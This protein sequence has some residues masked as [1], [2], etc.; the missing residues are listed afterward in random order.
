MHFHMHL[1][2]LVY[3]HHSS[4]GRDQLTYWSCFFPPAYFTQY[5]NGNYCFASFYDWCNN[6]MAKKMKISIN[7]HVKF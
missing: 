2:I 6:K 4:K 5:L 1:V 7:N 3:S